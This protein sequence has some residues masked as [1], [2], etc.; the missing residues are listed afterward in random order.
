M[1]INIFIIY[2]DLDNEIDVQ[3]QKQTQARKCSSYKKKNHIFK[4]LDFLMENKK[5]KIFS[6]NG[7]VNVFPTLAF[8]L[9]F[10]NS[11]LVLFLKTSYTKYLV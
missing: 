10:R 1:L 2:Q 3:L 8:T 9:K 7:N 4:N 5:K 11:L 6:D